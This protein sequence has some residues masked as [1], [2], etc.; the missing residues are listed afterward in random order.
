MTARGPL[1]A[2]FVLALSALAVRAQTPEAEQKQLQGT[3]TVT[4]VTVEEKPVEMFQNG[5]LIIEGDKA[6][7]RSANEAHDARFKIVDATAKPKRINFNPEGPSV[8]EGIYKLEGDTLTI[9]FAKDGEKRPSEF[10]SRGKGLTLIVC[11][12]DKK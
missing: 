2:A 10:S 8:A 11:K 12:R 1:L 6:T 9:C 7:I 4:T 3:Y 5:K